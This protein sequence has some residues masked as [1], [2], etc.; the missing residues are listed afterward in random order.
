MTDPEGIVTTYTYDRL[1]QLKSISHPTLGLTSYSYDNASRL[2]SK[3]L[4]NGIV[5]SYTFDDANRLKSLVTK[6]PNQTVLNQFGYTFDKSGN[7]LTRTTPEGTTTYTYDDL[8][9]LKTVSAEPESFTYDPVGN[10]LTDQTGATYTYDDANRL[11]SRNRSE[12]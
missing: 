5:T 3:T 12:D 10:R 9:Q 7:R 11:L 2:E 1:N 6:H 4:P 8:Y